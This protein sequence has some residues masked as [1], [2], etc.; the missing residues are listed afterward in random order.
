MVTIVKAWDI[1]G[2]TNEDGQ[3]LCIYCTGKE[4]TPLFASDLG[5]AW[6]FEGVLAC[7]ECGS[8]LG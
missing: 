4:D 3:V 5:S 7:E 2:Y 1:V 8:V 6:D